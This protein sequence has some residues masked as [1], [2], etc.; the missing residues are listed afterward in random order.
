MLAA[1]SAPQRTADCS[2]LIAGGT[3]AE[4]ADRLYK[5]FGI[6]EDAASDTLLFKVFEQYAGITTR[7]FRELEAGKWGQR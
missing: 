1:Y 5:D 2:D 4:L 3:R 6:K 7:E